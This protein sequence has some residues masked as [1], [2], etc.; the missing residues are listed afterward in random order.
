ME[1]AKL[2]PK[3][4]PEQEQYVMDLLAAD[5][6]PEHVTS[7]FIELYGNIYLDFE[8]SFVKE[9]VA[10]W[11]HNVKRRRKD[12]IETLSEELDEI[13][14]VNFSHIPIAN[15]VCRLKRLDDLY[16][17]I[18]DQSLIRIQ[19]D[20]YGELYKIMRSNTDL[21]LKVLEQAR[22]EL[23]EFDNVGSGS[24]LEEAAKDPYSDVSSAGGIFGGTT[25]ASKTKEAGTQ[26]DKPGEES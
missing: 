22:T 20:K 21:K 8:D 10:R 7:A 5:T 11:V 13:A 19:E 23:K 17:R 25:D 4:T 15:V 9:K 3:W 18:P 26:P 1:D 14:A 24:K 6:K 16:N 2:F 12:V